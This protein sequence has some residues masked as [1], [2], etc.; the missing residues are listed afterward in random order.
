VLGS[1]RF[2][3]LA[4]QVRRRVQSGTS[5]MQEAMD[6]LGTAKRDTAM[7]ALGGGA[8]QTCCPVQKPALPTPSLVSHKAESFAAVREGGSLFNF[9]GKA[10]IPLQ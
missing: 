3:E 4:A 5:L 8:P 2:N 7:I 10:G 6:R 9:P 1:E